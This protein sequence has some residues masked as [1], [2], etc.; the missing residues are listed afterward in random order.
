MESNINQKKRLVIGLGNPIL[1]DDGVGWHIASQLQVLPE[2]QEI[3]KEIE[4]KHLSL[5][6][7]HLM[8]QMLGFDDVI[9][10]DSILTGNHPVGTVFSVDLDALPNLS[11]GH[12]TSTH[13][14]SLQNALAVAETMGMEIP[15][16]VWIIA[17]EA[18][19]LYEFSV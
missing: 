18:I 6:G 16:S 7:L 14:T 1:G 5:G 11:M 13:D 12:T 15:K 2:L 3:N 4:Y 10:I 17:I 19:N 9:I 8:E